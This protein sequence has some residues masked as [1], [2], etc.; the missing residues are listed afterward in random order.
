MAS[1]ENRQRADAAGLWPRR[2]AAYKT[3]DNLRAI[4]EIAV[5]ALPL[6]ALWAAM[7][8]LSTISLWLTFLVAI[9]AAGFLIRLFMIQHDC[10]HGAMF[11]SRAANDWVGRAIGVITLTPYDFWR[12]AHAEHH[13]GSGNLDRRGIGDIDTITV[14]EYQALKPLSRL[15]Y[16]LYRH[17]AV[18]FGLGPAYLFMLRHR[19][20]IGAMKDGVM[21]WLSTQS[22]N[23]GIV[24]ASIALI[25][26]VGFG[27]FLAVQLP[28]VI[29]GASLGVWLF[30]VQHQFEATYWEQEPDWSH[31]D[32]A[33]HGS[34]YYDLPKPLM[35]LTGNIGVHH[36]HH[37]SSRIPMHRLPQV[38][39]DYPQ[40]KT[41]GR[42]TLRQS[43][44]CVRLTLWDENAKRLVSFREASA[45]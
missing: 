37:L 6:A 17:P 38:L 45:V 42:L 35:W 39:R 9:P 8:A 18:M 27:S 25:Y 26:T 22:T 14:R 16:R 43:L 23:L 5:T 44:K 1:L 20:P 19:L 33:L 32:A 10:G 34:S 7:W 2:L 12:K 15:R 29:G 36:V 40:L 30:Y 31:P 41:I 13:A 11:T 21:P 24:L 3:P 4:R 28:L